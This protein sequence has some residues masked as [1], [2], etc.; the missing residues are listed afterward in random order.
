M[1]KF[2]AITK[3]FYSKLVNQSQGKFKFEKKLIF[4]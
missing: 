4:F 1:M 2:N 3:G